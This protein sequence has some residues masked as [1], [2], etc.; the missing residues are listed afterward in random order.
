MQ[1][2]ADYG[3]EQIRE[4]EIHLRGHLSF[5]NVPQLLREVKQA[6]PD[7]GVLRID[8]SAVTRSDSAG[9][10]LLVDCLREARARDLV[11]QYVSMPE[12]M[13]A[14][15]RVSGLDAVLPL[16]QSQSETSA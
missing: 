13:L 15:A 10:A 12:Q 5:A 3:F 11:L 9:L 7:S 16:G 6:L 1:A 4:D 8:L 14:M 2:A